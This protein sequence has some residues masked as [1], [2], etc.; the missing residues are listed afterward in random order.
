VAC[1]VWGVVARVACSVWGA[2]ARVACSVWG[3]MARMACSVWGAMA[4]VACSV[5]GAMARVACSVWGVM[6]GLRRSSSYFDLMTLLTSL[7][8][9]SNAFLQAED[10]TSVTSHVTYGSRAAARKVHTTAHH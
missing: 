1:S 9:S 2:M 10:S 6:A 3:A 7:L 4:R 8:D 5:W